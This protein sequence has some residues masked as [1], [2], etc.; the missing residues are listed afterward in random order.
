[1][2]DSKLLLSWLLL[3]RLFSLLNSCR[4]SDLSAIDNQLGSSIINDIKYYQT[5]LY[6]IIIWLSHTLWIRIPDKWVYK[7]NIE[8]GPWNLQLNIKPNQWTLF[9][10]DMIAPKINFS[11][12]TAKLNLS[13]QLEAI[14]IMI[15][16]G[17]YNSKMKWGFN[18]SQSFLK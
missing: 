15:I 8:Y 4:Y 1:M 10:T 7:V 2:K 9:L 13:I 14:I 17:F 18:W 5:L 6:G 16:L 3:S 12:D 11:D